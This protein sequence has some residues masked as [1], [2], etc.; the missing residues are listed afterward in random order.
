VPVITRDLFL[1][2]PTSKSLAEIIV[3]G[4]SLGIVWEKPFRINITRALKP[5]D[6]KLEIKVTNLWLIV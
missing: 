4:K 6:H 1:C 3:N 2:K 5:G